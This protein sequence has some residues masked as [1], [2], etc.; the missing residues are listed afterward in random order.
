[1]NASNGTKNK[2]KKETTDE[3]KKKELKG[4]GTKIKDEKSRIGSPA[5]ESPVICSHKWLVIVSYISVIW[6]S[7]YHR[8]LF[9][10][11]VIE[12]K[13]DAYVSIVYSNK[14]EK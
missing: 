13:V 5:T 14:T 4:E 11:G 6:I 9:C 8:C 2:Q 10:P 3:W 1:M 12:N 7:I